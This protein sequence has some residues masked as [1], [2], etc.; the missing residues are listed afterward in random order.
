MDV[1]EL[2]KTIDDFG[3]AMEIIRQKSGT[4]AD[5]TEPARAEMAFF[6]LYLI[7]DEGS[8]NED[9]QKI[10]EEATGFTV[11]RDHWNEVMELGRVDS[12][13]KYLS[14]PPYT[15][16]VMVD[17][18]NALHEEGQERVAYNAAYEVYKVLG[19]Y[20]ANIKGFTDD[21]RQLKLSRFFEM[22]EKY[23]RDNTKGEEQKVVDPSKKGVQAPKKS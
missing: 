4:E 19:E 20:L 7:F 18:D 12:E 3:K 10:I 5:L 22:T 15:F 9:E 23:R 11:N 17:I 14:Q 16:T 1:K 6:G 8:F 21:K 2:R 13:E